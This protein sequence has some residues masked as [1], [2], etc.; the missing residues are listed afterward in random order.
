MVKPNGGRSSTRVDEL[1][2]QY[3][4]IRDHIK[5]LKD[6]HKEE[7]EEFVVA[8]D[9]VSDRLLKFLDA[10]D[11]EMARTTHGTVSARVNTTASCS[12][13]DAFIQFVRV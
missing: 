4:V 13:P 12:D 8:L 1:V 6:R 2:A 9:K 5:E 3:I 10:N 11:I 7:L